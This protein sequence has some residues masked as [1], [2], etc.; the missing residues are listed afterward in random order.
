MLL[1]VS[2]YL[3]SNDSNM[4]KSEKYLQ[5]IELAMSDRGITN[6]KVAQGTGLGESTIGRILSRKVSAPQEKSLAKMLDFL[7]IE[8]D[9][10]PTMPEGEDLEVTRIG[11]R[12]MFFLSK[13][14]INITSLAA[15]LGVSRAMF[16]NV[17]KRGMIP[18][19]EVVARIL[20]FYP[21]LN[22][23]WLMC[24]TGDILVGDGV[25]SR[26]LQ[27][28]KY[29]SECEELKVENAKLR[30]DL[31]MRDQIIKMMLPKP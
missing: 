14:D 18:S 30:Q 27:D 8:H 21:K 5:Q 4:D 31:E 2:I 10:S 1:H 12:L 29:T 9:L 24:G 13:F 11:E 15:Q 20:L 3:L 6:Y 22:A 7:G 16:S 17:E 26:E 25:V 19:S 28:V 23:R